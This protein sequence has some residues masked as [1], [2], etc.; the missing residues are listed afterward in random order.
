MEDIQ[1]R[2]TRRRFFLKIDN[3]L[4]RKGFTLIEILVVLSIMMIML[5]I[6]T[7]IIK[8][9]KNICCSVDVKSCNNSIA[10]FIM[11][12]KHY[13]RNKK[14]PGI[15]IFDTLN[16]TIS[17]NVYLNT[18]RKY[19]LP[20]KFKLEETTSKGKVIT[21]NSQ[22]LTGN[23]CTIKYLDRKGTEHK[24][25]MRVEAFYEEIKN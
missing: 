11:E 12:S 15:I 14:V 1:L 10:S 20:D 18:I 7:G 16:D 8:S 19:K 6:G 21:V 23:A 2:M 5:S 13:C 24:I 22:G 25:T 4:P 17:L 9:Y 3:F